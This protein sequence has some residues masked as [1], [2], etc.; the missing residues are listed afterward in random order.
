MSGSAEHGSLPESAPRSVRSH[1]MPTE[2]ERSEIEFMAL[3]GACS[4]R[5]TEYL[6][7]A[8][9][10]SIRNKSLS[11]SAANDNVETVTLPVSHVDACDV[12]V[13]G[14][15]IAGVF[16]ALASAGSGAPTVLIERH[17]FVGG[18]GTAG[19]VHTFC[20]ETRLV[21]RYWTEMVRRL[22]LLGAIAEYRPNDDGREFE[23]EPLKFVLQEMLSENGVRVLLHTTLLNVERDGSSIKSVYVLNKSGITKLQCRIVVDA[24]GDADVIACG[25]WRYHKGGPVFVPGNSP[26]LDSSAQPKQLPMSLYFTLVDSGRAVRAY[27]P[28]DCPEW[29]GDDDV[30]M[31]SV[32]PSE[33][34][35]TVKMKVIGFDATDGESLSAAEQQGRRQM[36]GL[37]YHLQHKGY[38]GRRYPTY[39]LAWVAPNIGIREG[40]RVDAE[41][42]LSI[43]ELMDGRSSDDA[44][45]VG[46]YHMDYHWPDVVQRAGTGLTTQVPPY[47]IPLEAMIPCD[48]EN[49]LVPGRCMS[50][51]QMAM[52]SFRVMGI[53]AQTGFAAGAAASLAC[54]AGTPIREIDRAQLRE[55]LRSDGVR[56]DL[57]P[58]GNYLR[59]RRAAFERIAELSAGVAGDV[60]VAVLPG[61]EVVAAWSERRDSGW[62]IRTAVRRSGR[63]SAPVAVDSV[64]SQPG[65]RLLHGATR[66]LFSEY[67]QL[68]NR[69]SPQQLRDIETPVT[70]HLVTTG[71]AFESKDSGRTWGP[72]SHAAAQKQNLF[73]AIIGCPPLLQESSGTDNPPLTAN[74]IVFWSDELA[75]SL[76]DHR[77]TLW[78]TTDAVHALLFNHQS[79]VAWRASYERSSASWS[80][81]QRVRLPGC[82]GSVTALVPSPGDPGSDEHC[83][84]FLAYAGPL[85]SH[86]QDA[87]GS[88]SLHSPFGLA[89]SEDGGLTWPYRNAES[90][91]SAAPNAVTI[92]PAAEGAIVVFCAGPDVFFRRFAPE[93]VLEPGQ[94]SIG[95]DH[96]H[97]DSMWI[98]ELR[99]TGY[100]R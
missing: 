1:T 45:A 47:H 74:D 14:G 29:G 61:G 40:R 16:A 31:I 66:R 34:T 50:G 10:L 25:G 33:N 36:M 9:L 32:Y 51:E 68:T 76:A 84:P 70:L 37:I 89:L 86:A 49:V 53:C 20:G 93:T 72:S 35:I 8:M 92:V 97:D 41:H 19:G 23:R 12:A 17:G 60:S 43:E 5:L 83:H 3:F 77:C 96:L 28:P 95:V 81:P 62:R 63:W 44:V 82:G 79:E 88:Q 69:W 65:V 13:V 98:A 21:N 71:H 57:A 7:R 27:L 52:S 22:D 58:Y 56:F 11:M 99:A 75:G 18:Q 4:V 94:T 80:S 100:E 26:R 67:A 59:P 46:S 54:S 90:E 78:T 48:T 55:R 15:G 64:E 30:P 73:R 38:R 85:D 24:T 2:S 91:I 6:P 39:E 87:V 42:T